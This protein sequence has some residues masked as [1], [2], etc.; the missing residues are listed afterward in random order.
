[1]EHDKVTTAEDG[2]I[3]ANQEKEWVLETDGANLKAVMCIDGV[4]FARTYSNNCVEVFNVLR[5]EAAWGTIMKELQN[6]IEFDGSYV[7]ATSPFDISPYNTTPFY[8]LSRGAT[9]PTYSPT[10]PAH[11][12]S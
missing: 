4:H 1:M 3:Q 7:G 2:S 6:V 10:S 9:S 11:R 8:N 12:N 5:I